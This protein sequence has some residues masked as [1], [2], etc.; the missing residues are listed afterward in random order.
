MSSLGPDNILSY[1]FNGNFQTLSELISSGKSGSFF[2]YSQDGMFVLKCIP[3][4]EFKQMK[5]M[6]ENY[7]VYLTEKNP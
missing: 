4:H 6:L 7:H 3:R 1:F 5:A 2:Y